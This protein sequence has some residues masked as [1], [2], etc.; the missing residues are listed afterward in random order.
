MELYLCK[1]DI[2]K[3]Y[4]HLIKIEFFQLSIYIYIYIYIYI[5]RVYLQKQITPVLKCALLCLLADF[6]SSQNNTTAV[7]LRLIGM[8]N[9]KNM[10]SE[11][12]WSSVF[13]NKLF[14]YTVHIQIVLCLSIHSFVCI[15][16]TFEGKK[17]LI[18]NLY[19]PPAVWPYRPLTIQRSAVTK[20]M[21]W[22]SM[23]SFPWQ[24][25][26]FLFRG[27]FCE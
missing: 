22:T 9:E 13:A 25:N 12:K 6:L 26:R 20:A 7:L 18:S 5:W 24:H 14:I 11:K 21:C 8:H 15:L 3:L 10:I 17:H 2:G 1:C 27:F 4:E 16:V 19:F 23:E